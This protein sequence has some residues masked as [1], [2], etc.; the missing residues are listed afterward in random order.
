MPEEIE[1]RFNTLEK[2]D[3]EEDYNF[4]H[5]TTSLLLEDGRR[6]IEARG[7]LPGELAPDFELPQVGGETLRLSDLRGQPTI[8]HFGSF[9]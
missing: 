2:R 3:K 1:R 7:I 8:L 4:K 9:S 6:T 5:F